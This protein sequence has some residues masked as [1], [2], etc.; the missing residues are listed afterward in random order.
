PLISI[1]L[2]WILTKKVVIPY[3]NKD[4]IAIENSLQNE[5]S[6]EKK[7]NQ[8]SL[9][10]IEVASFVNL[11]EA[12]ELLEKLNSENLLAYISKL[13]EYVVYTCLTFEKK[14]V[15]DQIISIKEDYPEAKINS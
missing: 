4:S 14:D 13:D 9:Y 6:K 10:N 3:L 7:L 5:D 2:G 8:I 15:E 1:T 11:E 12:E